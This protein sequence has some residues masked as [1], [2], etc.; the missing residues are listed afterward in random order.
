MNKIISFCRICTNFVD[1]AASGEHH[2][3]PANHLEINY[4]V[5]F[6]G[7]LGSIGSKMKFWHPIE[8]IK[9]LGTVLKLPAKEH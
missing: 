3:S 2:K 7:H 5:N 6:L 9:I 1:I 8:E 4:Y